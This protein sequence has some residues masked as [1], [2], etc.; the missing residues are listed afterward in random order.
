MFEGFEGF[1]REEFFF[2]ERPAVIVFPAEKKPGAVPLLK[3]EYWNA[4]PEAEKE[5]LRRGHALL[6]IRNDDR[7]ARPEDLSRKARFL[8][9]A[10][11]KYGLPAR[12]IP[13]GMSCG[14]QIAVKFASDFPELVSALYLDAPV[15]NY[16]SCPIGAGIG[17]ELPGGVKEFLDAWD[18]TLS[19]LISFRDMPMDRIGS[20][21]EN[22]IPAALIAGDSDQTVP[23]AENGVWLEKAYESTDIPFFFELKKGCDHHPHGP[24]EPG[25]LADFLERFDKEEG[26]T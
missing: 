25:R 19:D 26:N 12:A 21:L 13:V 8:R 15:M 10:A 1:D 18:M 5:M 3:C 9:Y 17:K 6:F 16:V 23:F 22:R 20:L 24:S 11:E 7:W 2:E 4:F 14:G